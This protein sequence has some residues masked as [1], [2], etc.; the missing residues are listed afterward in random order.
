MWKVASVVCIL[1]AAHNKPWLQIVA[2]VHFQF[3]YSGQLSAAAL[4]RKGE[5]VDDLHPWGGRRPTPVTDHLMLIAGK[6]TFATRGN[7]Y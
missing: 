3:H 7:I 4:G 1:E 6:P 2:A 5:F